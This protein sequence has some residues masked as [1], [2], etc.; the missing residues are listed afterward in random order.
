MQ[1]GKIS[2]VKILLSPWLLILILL[3]ALADM[4]GK[5][6]LVF[7]A[8]LWHELAHARMAM[9]LGFTVGE[10]ELLP[11]GGV[12]RI[13]GLGVVGSRQEMMIAAAGPVAS[14]VL[15][16]ISYLVNG[17][18]G[19]WADIWEF[20]YQTNL[21]LA[22]FNLL[23]GL[24]LDGGRILRAWLG[25]HM[26]YGKAT[27]IAAW[28][29]KWISVILIV[30]VV[31]EYVFHSTMNL[32][33]LVAALFLY[34]TANSE[35]Q[36]AGFRTLRI[37]SRKKAELLKRGAMATT[38]FTVLNHVLLKDLVKLF[39]A[40]QYYIVRIVDKECNL[41]GTVTETQ[42]WDELPIKGLYATIGEV[43]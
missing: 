40:D 38:Y 25:M 28:V 2:R 15:A 24:P 16:A 18:G 11:F 26:E 4:S 33:F 8:V 9:K 37:L 31:S 6:L 29:S 10:I 34:T 7:S 5:V 39:Q 43:I 41:C 21:M 35:V 20:Y 19:M 1:I 3:F 14:L 27:L 12:A 32:T 22:I 23:P 13:E 36:V 42:I 17:Y 30:I